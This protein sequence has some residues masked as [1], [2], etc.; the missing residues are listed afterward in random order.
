MMFFEKRIDS[1]RYLTG[2]LTQKIFHGFE[3]ELG[4]YFKGVSFVDPL[5][6]FMSILAVTAE[7]DSGNIQRFDLIYRNRIERLKFRKVMDQEL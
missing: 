3:D 6:P 5:A 2:K 1:L 4:K 7:V